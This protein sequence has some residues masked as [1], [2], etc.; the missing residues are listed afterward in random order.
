[1]QHATARREHRRWITIHL[2]IVH[3]VACAAGAGA[4]ATAAAGAAAGAAVVGVRLIALRSPDIAGS[5]IMD[6]RIVNYMLS[7]HSSLLACLPHVCRCCSGLTRSTSTR[8]SRPRSRS[9]LSS[10][11]AACVSK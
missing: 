11:P 10:N 7:S 2:G 1:M 9:Q 8:A 5:V 6:C 3:C 4:G